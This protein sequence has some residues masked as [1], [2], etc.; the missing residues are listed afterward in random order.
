MSLTNMYEGKKDYYST[1]KSFINNFVSDN[2]FADVVKIALYPSEFNLASIN[3]NNSV[4]SYIRQFFADLTKMCDKIKMQDVQKIRNS[5]DVVKTVLNVRESGSG[6]ISYDNVFNHLGQLEVPQE[7]LIQKAISEK[8][9]VEEDFRKLINQVVNSIQ[10]Y[11]EVNNISSSIITFDKFSEYASQPG[12]SV[13]EAIKMYK[14]NV[15]ALY[16]DLSNLRALD[17]YE[18]EKDYFVIRDKESTKTL[19][20]ALVDF[21][22][23]GYSFFRTGYDLI[24]NNVDGAESSSVHLVSAPSNHGKS[25][26]LVNLAHRI[27][28]KNLDDFEENDCVLF[29]TLEDTIQKLARRFCSIFGNVRQSSVKNLY[30]RS[31]EALKA[32]SLHSLDNNL[33]S[34][35]VR[36]FQNLLASSIHSVTM[37]KVALVIK[38]CQE[39]VFSP[40]DIGKFIDRLKIEGL[41]VKLLFAD[42]LDTMSPT[43]NRYTS[44]DD[45]HGQG[46][47]TQE[48][49]ILSQQYKIPVFTA[50]QNTRGSENVNQSMSNSHVGDSIRKVRYSDYIYMARQDS[51]KLPFDPAVAKYVITDEHKVNGSEQLTPE[52]L[53][54]CNQINNN[55][56]PFEIKITKAKEGGKDV[57]S[58][59][60]FCKENL[61]LYNNLG[62]Y[63]ADLSKLNN[64]SKILEGDIEMLTSIATSSISED[65]ADEYDKKPNDDMD[66]PFLS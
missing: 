40:G 45:Y 16:N 21:V 14:D 9:K 53:K 32:N 66:A 2:F 47:I 22:G 18:S 44:Y 48:L 24:D 4:V 23:T 37:G 65:F 51:T 25:I 19:A 36:M 10:A 62:E 50:T 6:I 41:N 30:R 63:L 17:K 26:F 46:Q 52:L 58:Y 43:I 28:E 56:I 35:I 31:Y 7:R 27:V 39:N 49:R 11:Y 61:R 20:E 8:L 13:F 54:M 38:H 59:M 5:I 15:I 34:K 64:K 3:G 33:E 1:I 12:V 60:L 55:L 29:I 57:M 42:Y